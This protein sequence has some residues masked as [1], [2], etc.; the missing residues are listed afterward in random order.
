VKKLSLMIV[1]L[2]LAACAAPMDTE[3]YL[4]ES[5]AHAVKVG[6]A[7]DDTLGKVFSY[8]SFIADP[9]SS[10][11]ACGNLMTVVSETLEWTQKTT[12]PEKQQGLQKTMIA[13]YSL[14][15]AGL[16]SCMEGK[17]TLAAEYIDLFEQVWSMGLAPLW[18][19]IDIP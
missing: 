17:F 6:D 10:K 1:V 9:A 13:S 2:A 4:T 8:S 12:P 18:P 19:Y 16:E 11:E 15:G 14:L 7:M 3:R 5:A